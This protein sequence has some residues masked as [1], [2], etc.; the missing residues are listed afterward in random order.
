MNSFIATVQLS[1]PTSFDGCNARAVD[2]YTVAV[3]LD[4]PVRA[5]T[6]HARHVLVHSPLRFHWAFA[7]F[8]FPFLSP[9]LVHVL[10]IVT[11]LIE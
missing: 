3:G 6:R 2:S 4:Q 7:N 1:Q 9:Q 11:K 8:F 10:A 5:G